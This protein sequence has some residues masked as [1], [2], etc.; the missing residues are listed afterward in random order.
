[1]CPRM[2]NKLLRN[3]ADFA[4]EDFQDENAARMKKQIVVVFMFSPQ[5]IIT[6]DVV[7]CAVIIIFS[8]ALFSRHDP[9]RR[10]L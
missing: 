10:Q 4:F 7:C 9:E 5:L 8:S 2:P 6:L 3:R 1:M